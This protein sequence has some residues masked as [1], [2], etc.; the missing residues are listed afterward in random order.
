MPCHICIKLHPTHTPLRMCGHR[1]LK[2][3]TAKTIQRWSW[4]DSTELSGNFSCRKFLT[5]IAMVH[6]TVVCVYDRVTSLGTESRLPFPR[7]DFTN[8]LRSNTR[9]THLVRKQRALFSLWF[10]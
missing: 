4:S 10:F 3:V 5:A 1:K 6:R 9:T 2:H 7:H 8:V